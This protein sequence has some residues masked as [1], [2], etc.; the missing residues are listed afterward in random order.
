LARAVLN[1]YDPKVIGI[2][3]SV[4]KS[5][6][7]EAIFVVLKNKFEV[8]TNIKNYNNEIGLPL[9]V[10]G[11]KSAGR[12]IFGW[13]MIFWHALEL[14]M[15]Q[16]KYPEV[17]IL[18]MGVDRIGDM[19]YLTDMVPVDIGI[20]TK[21]SQVHL[22]Y[23]KTLEN[24]AKEKSMLVRRLKPGGYGILN[25]DDQRVC[26]MK[27]VVNG[28][29]IS[30]GLNNEAQVRAVEIDSS[31]RNGKVAGLSFKLIYNG[32]VVPV[33][34]PN[35]LAE[36]FVYSALA[37]ASVGVIMELNLLEISEALTDFNSPLGRMRLIA[38]V[39]GSQIID[40]TY[41]AS[42][43]STI[44][45]LKALTKIENKKR[46]IAV[47]G[48]MLELGDY[49]K[50][51]HQKVGKEVVESLIDLLVV[52]GDRAKIIAN[53]ALELGFKGEVKFFINS[54]SAGEYLVGQLVAGDLVLVKGSQGIRMEKTV[55]KIMEQPQ[56]AKKLLVRQDESWQKR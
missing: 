28:R 13:L 37:A 45:A 1:K 50:E 7:K 16:K 14:I 20:I 22:E 51:G 10:L 25:I 27:N 29:F 42:P 18:E 8:R 52:V 43:E 38:G 11:E 56:E 30:F 55:K 31:Y 5:C 23:F 36:H 6:A 41:N 46:K 21:I 15:F 3:G 17:L 34:L 9:T 32:A 39:S 53:A 12:N 4:G 49:E 35:I 26:E 48:D 33:F 44:A 47:L 54:Q 2:T 24:I 19:K 40:D